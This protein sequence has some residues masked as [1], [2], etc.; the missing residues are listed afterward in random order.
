MEENEIDSA[1]CE[2]IKTFGRFVSKPIQDKTIG[3]GQGQNRILAYLNENREGAN[4]GILCDV[5]K[6]GSGR[7]GNALKELERKKMVQRKKDPHDKRKTIVLITKKGSEYACKQKEEFISRVKRVIKEV[8][9]EKFK[10]FIK[11]MNHMLDINDEI[12]REEKK[13]NVQAL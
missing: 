13:D 9:V 4:P 3:I 10:D 8:G 7:I 5:L 2:F 12:D 11:T 6:V 1:F